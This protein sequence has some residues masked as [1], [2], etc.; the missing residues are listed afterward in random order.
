MICITT[1]K[2]GQMSAKWL[3]YRKMGLNICD[4]T[5]SQR[6]IIVRYESITFTENM[7]SKL[8]LKKFY[9]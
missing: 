7:F 8:V 1:L 2:Y 3:Q 6:F 9:N 4:S 5:K